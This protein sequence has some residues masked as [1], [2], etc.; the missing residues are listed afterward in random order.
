MRQLV[1]SLPLEQRLTCLYAKLLRCHE[2]LG[3]IRLQ[4]VV[5]EELLQL[6]D[7]VTLAITAQRRVVVVDVPD[8]AGDEDH[9]DNDG[10]DDLLPGL[11]VPELLEECHLLSFQ[12]TWQNI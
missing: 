10:R 3:E 11:E 4:V 1:G 5:R 7:T 8:T 2:V 9:D 6:S 12:I